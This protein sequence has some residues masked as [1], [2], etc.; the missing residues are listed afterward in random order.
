MTPNF[1]SRPWFSV[2]TSWAGQRI[3]PLA[4]TLGAFAKLLAARKVRAI[5]ASNLDAAQLYEALDLKAKGLPGYQVLQPEYNRYDRAALEGDLRYVCILSGLGVV[6][7]F[8][9]ASG[10]LSRKYR[11]EADLTIAVRG[12]ASGKYLTPRGRAILAA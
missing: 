7:Y 5:G 10:F 11:T 12:K 1:T 6:T 2:A 9:L 3:K 8:G 4:E